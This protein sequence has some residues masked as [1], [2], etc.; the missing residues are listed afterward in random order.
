MTKSHKNIIQVESRNPPIVEL[1]SA[2]HAA[3]VRFSNDKVKRT[4]V[5]E[6]SRSLVTMD[7]NEAGGVVGVELVGIKEFKIEA[8]IKKAGI[9]GVTDYMLRK[10]SYVPANREPVLA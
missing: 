5:V 6:V 7:L 2:A 1:D 3:Y 4:E 9:R 8:L 10:T